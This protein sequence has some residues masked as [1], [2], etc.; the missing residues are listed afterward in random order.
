[1][2]L[3]LA[4]LALAA[5]PGQP[6]PDF[7][8][9]D[10][11][12]NPVSLADHSDKV[13]VLEWFN[14]GC[15]F[16]VYGHEDGPLKTL[17]PDISSEDL[18]YLAINSGAPGKQGHGI[19][20]NKAAA[21]KWA[22]THAI[23]V[24]EAGDVGRLYD[25][26]TTPQMVIIDKGTVVYNGAIDNAPKGRTKDPYRNHVTSALDEMKADQPVSTPQTKPYGCSVK[27]D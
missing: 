16:V 22:M 1:M 25:A 15:P 6:A 27:Y 10:L 2:T 7:S 8:L 17:A 13:V 9:P 19:E 21:E 14:P 20:K 12:G 18:V 26:K 4:S 11:D 3:L 24:D 5:S 23:L